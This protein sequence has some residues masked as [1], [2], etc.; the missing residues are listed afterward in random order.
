MPV[1]DTVL[2]AQAA[3]MRNRVRGAEYSYI[4]KPWKD[5]KK[6]LALY[7]IP[8]SNYS[9]GTANFGIAYGTAGAIQ[10]PGTCF[11]TYYERYGHYGNPDFSGSTANPGWSLSGSPQ[12]AITGY[13]GNGL[14]SSPADA[15]LKYIS[16]SQLNSVAQTWVK[17]YAQALSK[18]LLGVGIR[19]KFN[20]TLPIPGAELTLNKDD[21]ISTGREDQ[22]ILKEVQKKL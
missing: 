21:L 12:S 15:G 17:K 1:F 11:Y 19:G 6:K 22:K 9:G 13:Q 10:T 4:I 18:E 3:E 20:G 8:M 2:T 14:V 16:Y 5:G 7:P